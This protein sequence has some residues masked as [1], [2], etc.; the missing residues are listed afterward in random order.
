MSRPVGILLALVGLLGAAGCDV[1]ANTAST[2]TLTYTEDARAAYAEAMES[3]RAKEWE[4]AKAL[5]QEVK[6]LFA[7]SRYARLAE[8]RIADIDFEQEKFTDAIA[9]YREFV[10]NHRSDRDV[11]YAK[12]RITKAL[13]LDIDDTILLPPQQ[14]RAQ[15]TA[16]EA[17]RELRAFPKEFLR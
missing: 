16:I 4:D 2:A 9:A 6:R 13:F 1:A 12:Y 10:Q 15:A 17:H 14:E 8:L 11:A 5:M 7:Y 3:F